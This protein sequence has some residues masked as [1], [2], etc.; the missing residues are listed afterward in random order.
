[1]YYDL[2]S[3]ISLFKHTYSI[4]RTLIEDIIATLIKLNEFT[5]VVGYVFNE[6]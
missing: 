6:K 3:G 2:Y 4:S 5:Q 1:M